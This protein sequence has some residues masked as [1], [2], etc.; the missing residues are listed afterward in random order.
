[1]KR[2]LLALALCLTA[3]A[4]VDPAI[5]RPVGYHPSHVAYYN[6]PYFANALAHGGEWFEFTGAEF[7]TAVAFNSKPAQFVNGYPQF[8]DPGQKLR[9]FLFGLNIN[10][11]LRPA[12]WPAR[13]T[14]AKGHI[15]MTWAGNADVRLVNCTFQAGESNG[16][17]T[18]SISNGRRVYLCSAA[19]QTIEIHAIQTP[20]TDLKVWLAP[21]DDPATPAVNENQTGTLEGELFHPLLLDRIADADWGFIRFMD[22]GNTNASPQQEWSDRRRPGHIFQNGIITA[23]APSSGSDPNRETGVAFE[24][25][26]ALCNATGRN[27]WITIP[28][29]ATPEYITKLARLIRFGSNGSEPYTTT[30]P[31]AE[32]PPLDAGLKV[33]VEFSNEIWSSGFAFAQGNW[34]QEQ[35][36]IAGLATNANDLAG[37]ARFTGRRFCDTWRIFQDVFG[38]TSRLVRVAAIFTANNTYS[39]AF[40]EEIGTYGI[41]LS[42]QVRPDVLAVTTYF[43]NGIQ[44]FVND[45]GFT[46]GKLFNDPYWTSPAFASHLTIA[47]DEWK[48]RML[49]GD[50][51]TG[52]GPDATGIGGGFSE[53]LRTLPNETLGYSLPIVAYEGGPSLFTNTIDLGAQSGGVPTDDHVTTFV[54]AMNR[55]P[56]IADVYRIHLDLAKSKGLWTHTPYVDSSQWGRFGQWGHLENLEQP[57]AG[58]PKYALMLEHFST[59]STLKHIDTPAGLVPSFTTN[60]GMTPG[61]VGQAYSQDIVTS[62]GNGARTITVIGAFLEPG[63]SIAAA[64]AAGNLRISGTP[65]TSRKN[66]I[67]ARVQD[68]DGDPAWRIFTL[69]TFG[70]PGTLVQSDFRGDD[71]A[72]HRPWTLTFV[73]SPK[74]TWSGWNIGA[75]LIPRAGDD[76]FF[77]SISGPAAEPGSTLAQAL[78][79]QEYL[80]ATIT[81]ASGPLDLRGATFAFAIR[82]TGDHSPRRYALFSSIGGFAEANALYTSEAVQSF[83]H[84]EHEHLVTLPNTAPFSAVN[85]AVEFRI[86]TFSGKFDG[87]LASLTGFKLTEEVPDGP[88]AAATNLVAT[89]TGATQ[90]ALTWTASPFAASYQIFRRSGSGSESPIG[91]SVV[92][93]FTDT[94]AAASTAHLY[95][96]KAVAD[97][98]TSGFSNGSLATTV[99]FTDEPLGL[100]STRVKRT[101]LIELR[102]A[103]NAVR[104]LAGLTAAAFTDSVVTAGSTKVRTVHLTELRNALSSALTS[105]GLPA[106]AFSSGTTTGSKVLLAHVQELRALVK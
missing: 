102:T 14:L 32:F 11:T 6:T 45:E 87:H 58:A 49:A 22:W 93:A 95:R 98:G 106:P 68:A 66:Y 33:Y 40:L 86:Y 105:L 62:G 20:I 55:D 84:D 18:G 90:V 10:S 73:L 92:A 28:H 61:I 5:F 1:M 42:P 74:V 25:M 89:A 12:A 13:D 70:G 96:V 17:A 50:A 104:V 99:V 4:Q 26:V 94:T 81:P 63:L 79:E 72:L 15:V 16:A 41:T 27:M 85:A 56:R 35:A 30:T 67:L 101:H 39:E 78:A 19:L 54:E 88:P 37:R 48:R 44:D 34:A 83:D 100:Q 46:A 9:G 57:P 7:G 65:T 76:A 97:G 60:A 71:P 36:V 47:F 31:S 23:R 51:S 82:R 69:Q 2:A 52:A 75:G 8:L 38:G 24:H 64:P 103:V 59:F 77:F 80:T 3:Q 91:T 29:L 53:S 21:P 43:G